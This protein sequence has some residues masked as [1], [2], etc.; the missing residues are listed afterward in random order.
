MPIAVPRDNGEARIKVLDAVGGEAHPVIRQDAPAIT[1]PAR[2]APGND[3]AQG[4][5]SRS[6]LTG[7]DDPRLEGKA[8][9]H[10]EAVVA[11]GRNSY[12]GRL[13]IKLCGRIRVAVD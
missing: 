9:P 10:I 8:V 12:S 2:P 11:S 5:I 4:C 13:L 1:K 6:P 3:P 7:V